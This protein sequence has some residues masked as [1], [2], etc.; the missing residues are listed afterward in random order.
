MPYDES[1][2]DQ[3]TKYI[4]DLITNVR[5]FYGNE[6]NVIIHDDGIYINNLKGVVCS[7][8]RP[9][10]NKSKDRVIFDVT[11]KRF[12]LREIGM[13]ANIDLQYV[14]CED[15][16]E[17]FELLE[18]EAKILFVYHLDLLEKYRRKR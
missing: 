2:L 12:S 14:K 9:I 17:W 13:G 1:K 16:G 7:D 15:I 5:A 18:P 8:L 11:F 10:K 3:D 4:I 6:T